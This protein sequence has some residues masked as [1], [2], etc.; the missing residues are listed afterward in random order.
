MKKLNVEEAKNVEPV[1]HGRTSLVIATV[2]SLLVGEILI[3]TR[4][5]W[6]SKRPPYQAV[7]RYAKKSGRKFKRG[8]A[9]DGKG[10]MVKRVG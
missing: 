3:V 6:K 10:W 7:D 5:D 9:P 2:S 1:T 4:E 8:K